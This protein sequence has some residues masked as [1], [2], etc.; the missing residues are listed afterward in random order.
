[1]RK[2]RLALLCL[3]IPLAACASPVRLENPS[4]LRTVE[5][6]SAF[7][8][9]SA[10]GPAISGILERTYSNA[11]QQDILLA[12][13]ARTPGQNMLRVQ[14]FGPVDSN[15][16]GQTALRPGF[17]APSNIGSEMRAV[18]PG[19]PMQR[20]PF[21][22]QNQYGPFGYAVGRSASGD[23]CFYGWQRIT[24]TGTAQTWIGNKG[25]IQI[26]LRLCQ[27]GATEE[28]LLQSMYGFT[29]RSYFRDGNWNPFGEPASPSETLG[30][31]GQPIYPTSATRFETVSPT[32]TVDPA[33]TPV[34][35]RQAAPA[36]AAVDTGPVRPGPLPAPVGPMVPP[37]PPL[38]G[39][40]P[41]ALPAATLEGAAT[42]G[43]RATIPGG[44]VVPPPPNCPPGGETS[45]SC[46]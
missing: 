37:P 2:N 25:S 42:P 44:I 11:V 16:A 33:P 3:L 17:L 46:P 8:I 9:P 13:S 18:L 19:I 20:S 41:E 7:A 40:N 23:N 15:V 36:P 6:E 31:P 14:F 45:A 32:P 12:T 27:T 35:V 39:T 10:G 43:Q 34:R 24:S 1:M 29:V 4:P 30:R 22:V 28:Q 38:V 26:R 21:Y 5:P